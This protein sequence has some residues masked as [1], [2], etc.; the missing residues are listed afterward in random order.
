MNALGNRQAGLAIYGDQNTQQATT[1]PDLNKISDGQ[2]LETFTNTEVFNLNQKLMLNNTVY[3]TRN[4]WFNVQSQ[5]TNAAT[6]QGAFDGWV[7]SD[8]LILSIP[9]RITSDRSDQATI[10]AQAWKYMNSGD[11]AALNIFDLVRCYLGRNNIRV[12]RPSGELCNIFKASLND[13]EYSPAEADIIGHLGLPY[14]KAATFSPPTINSTTGDESGSTYFP[15]WEERWDK[16]GL[17]VI[18]MIGKNITGSEAIIELNIPLCAI[19]SYFKVKQWLPPNMPIKM[20]LQFKTSPQ[21]L[22]TFAYDTGPSTITWTNFSFTPILTQMKLFYRSHLLASNVQLDINQEWVTKRFLTN[23]YTYEYQEFI[24]TNN[25]TFTMNATISQQRPLELIFRIVPQN[26]SADIAAYTT[27]QD[28]ISPYHNYNYIYINIGGRNKIEYYNLYSTPNPQVGFRK[29]QDML[30]ATINA[31]QYPSKRDMTSYKPTSSIFQANKQFQTGAS[32]FELMRGFQ[33]PI[34]INPGDMLDTNTMATD[35]GAV[36]I[37][38]ELNID[39]LN[40]TGVASGDGKYKPVWTTSAMTNAYKLVVIKKY[41][42]Q[43]LLSQDLNVQ[44]VQWPAVVSQPNQVF[45]S[46]TFNNN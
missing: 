36:S 7:P 29:A 1:A 23:Y 46:N 9:M 26:Q 15:I 8:S 20:E 2:N 16:C 42:E 28:C 22:G 25:Q 18:D 44:L 41:P 43:L 33:L 4:S 14:T 13:N 37:T 27:Y 32:K 5:T 21:Q 24:G 19:V 6:I 35:Q 40:I 10:Y 34:V 39:Q 30:N 3:D 45:I 12:G 38:I 31:R 11:F 17:D